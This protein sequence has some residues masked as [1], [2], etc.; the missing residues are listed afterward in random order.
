MDT[1]SDNLNW[2]NICLCENG[3][4]RL[5]KFETVKDWSLVTGGGVTK[6]EAEKVLAML[7]VGG[8][9]KV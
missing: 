9:N 4:K 1:E 8:H 6:R 3:P 2:K 7:K 5:Q